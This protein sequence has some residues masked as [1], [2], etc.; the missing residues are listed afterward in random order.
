[1]M[2]RLLCILLSL[3]MLAA[4]S[5]ALAEESA[6]DSAVPE[7]G[8]TET[9][10][11]EA[12]DT[13]AAAAAEETAEAAAETPVLLATVNGKEIMSDN[14]FLAYMV[15]IYQSY[16][17]SNGYDL[18]DAGITD[19]INQIAMQLTIRHTVECQKAADL[20]L[21]EITDADKAAL[22]NE[23]KEEWAKLLHSYAK[24]SGAITDESTEEEKAA[25]YANV[26]AVLALYGYDEA[27][28]TEEVV[29]NG[30]E[31]ILVTRVNEY[32]TEGLS[33]SDEDVQAYYD[34]LVSE[35]QEKYADNAPL[36]E[37][38][39]HYGQKVYYMPEGYRGITHILLKVDDELL[40]AWK[41]VSARFEEQKGAEEGE[42][43]EEPVTE[44]MVKAAEQAILD[45]VKE[46][47]D[48]IK[49]KLDSGVS[50]DELMQEYG[51][52]PGMQ[53]DPDRTNGYAVHSNSIM[54]DQAFTKAAMAL[55]KVGD[56]S[57]PVIGSN[58]VHILHYLRDIPGG[59]AELTEDMKA[60]FR[61]AILEDL[62]SEAVN[63]AL[64]KWVEEAEIVYT[65]AGESWKMPEEEAAA[66]PAAEAAAEPADA[67]AE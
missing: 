27:S 51:T 56:V 44:E 50:F 66:E 1:M 49:A 18:T 55:E 54:W 25:A 7:A 42:T 53:R 62:S 22:E 14:T 2:K 43:A 61:A 3:C 12:A 6:A 35:D 63:S 24:D 60:E 30:I 59:A 33:V 64:D 65:E 4:A 23:G 11:A 8:T 26:A 41:D 34:E 16:A 48:E 47:V 32:C 21:D 10:T 52:D 40:S 19:A 58:G 67:P 36:Y 57:E 9:E 45:S 5:L 28:Y 31:N 20:G 37:Y 46:T 15:Y 38:A 17:Q 13:E 39:T 29:E